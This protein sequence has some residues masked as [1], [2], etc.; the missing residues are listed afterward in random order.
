MNDFFE[1]LLSLDTRAVFKLYLLTIFIFGYIYW[2]FSIAF[3]KQEHD[4]TLSLPEAI[5][6]SVVTITTLGYGD[7]SP[8]GYWGMLLTGAEA[9]IGIIT[10]GLFLTSVSIG[11]ANKN[12][13]S[14]RLN[15]TVNAIR[16]VYAPNYYLVNSY[17]Y[18][19]AGLLDNLM[20]IDYPR[21]DDSVVNKEDINRFKLSLKTELDV[22]QMETLKGLIIE[23]RKLVELLNRIYT[24]SD[25]VINDHLMM[26]INALIQNE[27]HAMI[28]DAMADLRGDKENVLKG[29]SDLSIQVLSGTLKSIEG[30]LSEEH[31]LIKSIK[32]DLDGFVGFEN[33]TGL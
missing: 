19:I 26:N 14:F 27:P 17:I 21:I 30:W 2:G 32:K 25:P 29:G 7:I 13:K 6:F 10:L 22:I 28:R 18:S 20:R 3:T 24:S 9:I 11:I 15:H 4:V 31:R 12:Q 23:K 16:F 33:E 5:Y 8:S 1:N